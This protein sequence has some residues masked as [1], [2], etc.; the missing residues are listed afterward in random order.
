MIAIENRLEP[1]RTIKISVEF[2]LFVFFPEVLHTAVAFFACHAGI[3]LGCADGQAL[4]CTNDFRLCRAW[5]RRA[6]IIAAGA[7]EKKR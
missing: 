6:G 2:L 1:P 4:L 7:D 3:V 5:G